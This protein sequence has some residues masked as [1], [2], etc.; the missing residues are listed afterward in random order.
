MI[1]A[2]VLVVTNPGATKSVVAAISEIPGVNELHEVMGPYDI[3]IELQ[4][5]SL[6][7]VPPILS[8]KIRTIP[9]IESTT[10]LVTFPEG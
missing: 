10:S 4:V 7:D 2:Y 9:G 1:K 5:S 3:V 8:D 6:A